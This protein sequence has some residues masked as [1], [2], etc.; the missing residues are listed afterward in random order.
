MHTSVEVCTSGEVV[1]P[2][3]YTPNGQLFVFL[4]GPLRGEVAFTLHSLV[5]DSRFTVIRLQPL[6]AT[7]V[8]KTARNDDEFVNSTVRMLLPEEKVVLTLHAGKHDKEI[9]QE[10]VDAAAE[11]GFCAT[12]SST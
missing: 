12:K 4:D 11:R 10:Q 1:L 7:V 5:P 6:S 8:R 9:I 2:L 3:R